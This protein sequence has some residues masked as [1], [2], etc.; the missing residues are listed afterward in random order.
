MDQSVYLLIAMGLILFGP[1]LIIS[2]SKRVKKW[3]KV[4]WV[5]YSLLP[6][7]IV[8][9]IIAI[10]VKAVV[11]S[12]TNLGGVY[13]GMIMPLP[14]YLSVWIMLF[15]FRRKNPLAIKDTADF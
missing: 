3:K 15:I 9:L 7:I 14:T 12:E 10:G 8:P 11:P 6:L 4:Q 13:I 1:A 2:F 5:I